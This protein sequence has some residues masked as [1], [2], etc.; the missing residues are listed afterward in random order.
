MRFAVVAFAGLAVA[1]DFP[2]CAKSCLDKAA[3]KVG[4]KNI[5]DSECICTIDNQMSI[6]QDGDMLACFPT[7]SCGS[8]EIIKAT[9]ALSEGCLGFDI[10]GSD[11]ESDSEASSPSESSSPSSDSKDSADE[12]KNAA[13]ATA[14]F[15]AA[16]F[17]ALLFAL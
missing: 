2:S 12:K 1:A 10:T 6:G 3:E 13:P 16:A 9:K 14:I 4:C 17:A 5:D 7:Q 11:S 15:G 8:D